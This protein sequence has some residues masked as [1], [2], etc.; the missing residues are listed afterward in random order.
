MTGTVQH[1]HPP[2]FPPPANGFVWK[3][4]AGVAASLVTMAIGFTGGAVWSH[5]TRI[6]A[7]ETHRVSD[8]ENIGKLESRVNN[9]ESRGAKR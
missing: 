4:L 1:N 6:T 5:N 8:K 9:L 7:L 3:I 2:Y